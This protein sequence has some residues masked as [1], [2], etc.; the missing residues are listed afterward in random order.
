MSNSINGSFISF[1]RINFNSYGYI[2][3]SLL[4][5]I[6]DL[7]NEQFMSFS[8]YIRKNIVICNK[9]KS[10]AHSKTHFT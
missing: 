6:T 10:H 7:K 3:D 4:H 1:I 9:G 2:Y 8:Q 5:A